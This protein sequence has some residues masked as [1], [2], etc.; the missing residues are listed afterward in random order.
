MV[1]VVDV[2]IPRFN[3]GMAALVIGVGF[4]TASPWLIVALFFVV[5]LTRFGGHR[6]GL[7]TQIYVRLF[8]PLMSAPSTTEPAAPPRFSQLLAV[9]FLGAANVGFATGLIELGWIISLTVFALALL[10]SVGRIC[11]GCMF[12]RRFLTQ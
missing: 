12:Y 6:V 1:D 2:R 9:I 4:V 7:F 11:V 5:V 8:R 3:Q 10:A